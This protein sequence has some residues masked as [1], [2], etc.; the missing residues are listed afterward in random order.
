MKR[1]NPQRTLWKVFSSGREA[2]GLLPEMEEFIEAIALSPEWQKRFAGY[3]SSGKPGN[4][5]GPAGHD[6]V[7]MIRLV[8]AQCVLGKDYRELAYLLVDS[9]AL[10]QFLEIEYVEE[11]ALPKFTTLNGW[12]NALPVSFLEEVNLAISLRRGEKK[13]EEGKKEAEKPEE[14]KEME[15]PIAVELKQWRSDASCV[16]SNIHYPTDSS[17]LRDGLRWMYRWI[18]R[19][20][21]NLC[22]SG[23]PGDVVGERTPAV[24]GDCEVGE[25]SKEERAEEELPAFD[26]AY[27]ASGGSL[28]RA[29]EEGEKSGGLRDNRESR[30]LC[31][32]SDDAGGVGALG[33]SHRESHGPSAAAGV[34]RKSG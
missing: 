5:Q 7:L 30:A 26:S 32:L 16:E 25:V 33:T 4:R 24:S 31:A 10:R 19:M 1:L 8:L 13:P 34:K 23:Q 22:A 17:L 18:E 12:M 9:K 6:I 14:N 21:G 28:S 27:R 20:R 29:C 3:W 15:E 2:L 11:Q